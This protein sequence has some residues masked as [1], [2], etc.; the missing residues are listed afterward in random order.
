MNTNTANETI[1]IEEKY[2]NRKFLMKYVTNNVYI[3]LGL[4][5][6]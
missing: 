3:I 6:I 5:N 2:E 4:N 1:P